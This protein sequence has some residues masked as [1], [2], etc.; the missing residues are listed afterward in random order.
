MINN[1]LKA[2][3]QKEDPFETFHIPKLIILFDISFLITYELLS[4]SS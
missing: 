4:K 1:P 2:P 3:G